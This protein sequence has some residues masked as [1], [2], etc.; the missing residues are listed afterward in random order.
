MDDGGL[1]SPPAFDPTL[2]CPRV[3]YDVIDLLGRSIIPQPQ[4][5][6]ERA[7]EKTGCRTC[8]VKIILIKIS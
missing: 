8:R 7:H 1:T 3:G 4:T 6:E 5:M 2:H